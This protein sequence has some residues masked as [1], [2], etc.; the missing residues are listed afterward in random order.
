MC[1]APPKKTGQKQKQE[2]RNDQK[3]VLPPQQ[4][5]GGTDTN[6]ILANN[7]SCSF[8]G[9]MKFNSAKSYLVLEC[10]GPQI[11]FV[12]LYSTIGDENSTDASDKTISQHLRLISVSNL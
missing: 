4:K 2:G 12:A 3:P 5:V 11:P 10:S 9:N 6:L 1:A 7:R 8:V